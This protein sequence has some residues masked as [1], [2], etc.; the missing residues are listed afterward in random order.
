[1][2]ASKPAGA[3]PTSV[4]FC[5]LYPNLN[6]LISAGRQNALQA[7]HGVPRLDVVR[8]TGR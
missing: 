2:R 5:A 4:E 3:M 7:D 6:S 8:K 1:M